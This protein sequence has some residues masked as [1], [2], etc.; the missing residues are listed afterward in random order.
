MAELRSTRGAAVFVAASGAITVALLPPYFVLGWQ[1]GTLVITA[2]QSDRISFGCGDRS[3]ATFF[4][5]ALFQR[6]LASADSFEAAFDIARKRVDE[7]EKGEGYQPPSNPQIW[8][9]SAM[10]E[11]LKT[12]RTKGQLGT[13][14]RFKS[15]SRDHPLRRPLLTKALAAPG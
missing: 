8:I 15:A 12:L 13:T 5:E 9:G 4:G 3:D 1:R 10:T 6:G 2:S 7:R 14:T 11:K